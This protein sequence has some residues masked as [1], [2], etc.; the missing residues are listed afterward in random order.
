MRQRGV[1]LELEGMRLVNAMLLGL[2]SALVGCQSLP[3]GIQLKAAGQSVQRPGQVALFLAAKSGIEPLTDLGPGNFE[4]FED[5][6]LINPAQSRQTLLDRDLVAQFH[7]MLLVDVSGEA[8]NEQNRRWIE[9]A[10]TGFVEKVRRTQGVTV[11]GFDGSETLHPLGSFPRDPA[12]GSVSAVP[13]LQAFKVQ[14]NSRDFRGAVVRALKALNT[15]LVKAGKPIQVGTLVVFTQGPDLT[16]RTPEEDFFG[17][18]DSTRREVYVVHL[19][20]KPDNEIRFA[21][22]EGLF[23][24]D[25]LPNLPLVLDSVANEVVNSKH[26]HYLLSYC[27]PARQGRRSLRIKVTAVTPDGSERT[28]SVV[29]EFDATGFGPGCDATATP[30]FSAAGSPAAGPAT[31]DGTSPVAPDGMPAGAPSDPS[32][33]GPTGV[34][35]ESSAE[36]A[37]GSPEEIVPP[38]STPNYQP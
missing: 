9:R 37:P 6:Q 29:S 33:T 11:Y 20:D 19:G 12:G 32:P 24:L 5:G 17:A 21:G 38:P 14:D 34:P 36:P 28:G 15:E 26:K 25:S 35:S 30:S 23:P 13:A 8:G 10:I 3:G 2:I 22:Q 7:T 18:L 27:S 16:G 1:V 31:T 4:V